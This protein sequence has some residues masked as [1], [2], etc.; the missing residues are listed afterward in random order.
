MFRS[1]KIEWSGIICRSMQSN[2]KKPVK[3]SSKRAQHFCQS[4]TAQVADPN[5]IFLTGDLGFKALEPLRDALGARFVNAGV[6]EQNMISVA[7]GLAKD[8]PAAVGLQHRPIS[9]CSCL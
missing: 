9:I 2:T 4:L 7:A 1:W 3:R 8:G 5:L 6:A